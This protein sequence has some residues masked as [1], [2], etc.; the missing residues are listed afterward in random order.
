M[1]PTQRHEL[2]FGDLA[3]LTIRANV[4]FAVRCA[5]RLRPCFQLPADAPRRREQTFAI[6]AA[7]RV[8]TGFCRGEPLEPGR[9]AAAVKAALIVAEDTCEDTRYAGYAAVRAAEVVVHAE[10]YLSSGEDVALTEAMAAAFGAGRV[11]A[12]NADAFATNQIVAALLAGATELRRLALGTSQ[13]LGASF[14]P[15][16]SGPLG[17]L[18]PEGAPA[19]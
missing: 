1:E 18:W 19:W 7:I 14:D 2:S 17:S 15:S 10:T 11:L 9:A 16:E 6:D 13:D 8:A 4:A 12:A 5:Q 3:D